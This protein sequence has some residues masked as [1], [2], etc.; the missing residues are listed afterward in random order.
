MSIWS[1]ILLG[2][3]QGFTE[4]LPVSSSGHLSIINNLFKMSDIKSGHI[5]FDALLHM[6]T[7]ASAVIVYWDDIRIM[8]YETLGIMNIGPLAEQRQSRYPAA[9]TFL[10]IVVAC[11]PIFLILPIKNQLNALYYRNVFIGVA[12][13][14]TGCILYVSD[15]MTPGKKNEGSM[16][17]LDALI[18]GLCQ[19][20]AVIPGLSRTGTVISAGIATGLKRDFALKFAFLLSLPAV[21]GSCVMRLIEAFQAEIVWANVPAYLLGTV[22]ALISGIGAISL[23]R[24]INSKGR[25]GGFAYYCWVIGV[26]SIILTMIF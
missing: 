3:V 17:V 10:M 15:K 24:Y 21:F 13:I 4:F 8:F 7:L 18:I 5:L 2:L 26:L 25:F 12:L 19:C 1:A 23:L 11:L 22:F 16:T 6:G 14:L 20:V 9:R